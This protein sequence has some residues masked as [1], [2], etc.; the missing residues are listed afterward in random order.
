MWGLR[1]VDGGGGG[2]GQADEGSKW[3][4][5]RGELDVQRDISQTGKKMHVVHL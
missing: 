5:I 1:S 3:E 2:G 4:L